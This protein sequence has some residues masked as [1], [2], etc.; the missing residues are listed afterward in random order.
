MDLR[1][2][3]VCERARSNVS[4]GLD[5]ELSELERAMLTAHLG[6]CA[7]CRRYAEEVSA[8]TEELRAAP[9]AQ[10]R[11]GVAVGGR[12]RTAVPFRAAQALAAAAVVVVAVGVG[13]S[14]GNDL[15][16][17]S[18]PARLTTQPVTVFDAD[19]DRIMAQAEPRRRAPVSG[20]AIPV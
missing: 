10:P 15:L 8:F 1:R 11:P 7:A 3:I 13:R 5:D 14:V 6:R 12:R 4:L 18:T 16:E 9:L 20:R 19:V 2:K 17:S